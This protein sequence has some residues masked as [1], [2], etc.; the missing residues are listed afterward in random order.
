MWKVQ[1]PDAARRSGVESGSPCLLLEVDGRVR[2][3]DTRSNRW[4]MNKGPDRGAGN[5]SGRPKRRR[6]VRPYPI[7]TLEEALAVPTTIHESNSGLP[8]DRELLARALGTTPASSGFTMRLTSSSRYGLTEGGYNDQLISLTREGEAI[9][10]PRNDDERLKARVDAATTP[11]VFRR[12]YEVFDG[13]RLPEDPY[14]ENMLRRE[15]GLS[16]DLTGECLNILK[17]NGFFAGILTERGGSVV[18]RLMRTPAPTGNVDHAAG[19][20]TAAVQP[21]PGQSAVGRS[22]VGRI[23]VGN[24]GAGE[25]AEFVKGVLEGFGIP[26]GT[27]EDV[28]TEGQPVAPAVSREMRNCTAAVLVLGRDGPAGSS[29]R[30]RR[31]QRTLYQ[32][33]AASVL[34]GPRVVVVKEAGLGLAD[35]LGDPRVVVFDPDSIGQVGFDLL[36]ALYALGVIRITL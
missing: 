23:F 14:A 34:Y 7:H 29:G 36:R 35:D 17:A 15:L 33:G 32:L 18:V 22:V 28:A 6:I 24:I 1:D 2:R 31:L 5:G 12:F 9:G 26:Y 3:H 30:D 11:D 27:A 25:A 21:T 20:I 4:A 8:M 10:A 19:D 13:K 16:M